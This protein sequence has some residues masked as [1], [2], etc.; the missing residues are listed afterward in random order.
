[1][2]TT[3]EL[4]NFASAIAFTQEL[5]SNKEPSASEIAQLVQTED[6]ARGFFVTYLTSEIANFPSTEIVTGLR[7]HPEIVSELLV[8][9]LAMSTAQQLFHRRRE[10]EDMASAS[11]R[12]QER[13][14]QLIELVDLDLVYE[15]LQQMVASIDADGSYHAFLKRWSYDDEQKQAIKVAINNFLGR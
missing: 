11:G 7:S 14:R 9:N 10:D 2:T 8:K 1:M 3:P 13:T 12:V 4:L 15:K 5:L 6:G